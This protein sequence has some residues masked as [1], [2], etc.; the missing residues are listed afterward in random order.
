MKD[1]NPQEQPAIRTPGLEQQEELQL[2]RAA[3]RVLDLPYQGANTKHL[4]V[5]TSIIYTMPSDAPS[6]SRFE[7]APAVVVKLWSDCTPVLRVLGV[8]HGEDFTLWTVSFT[9]AQSGTPEAAGAWSWAH[10]GFPQCCCGRGCVLFSTKRCTACGKGPQD[11]QQ[12]APVSL[13]VPQ[14]HRRVGDEEEQ[15]ACG[16]LVEAIPDGDLSLSDGRHPVEYG[17]GRVPC[18][19]CYPNEV[20]P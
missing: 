7:V 1:T 12:P 18:P 15:T 8:H 4:S 9:V 19:T 11:F 6:R 17:E 13:R 16:A 14:V 20:R 2:L 10:S 5:G 3:Q